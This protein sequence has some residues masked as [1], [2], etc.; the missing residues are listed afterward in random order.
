MKN[1]LVT[2]YEEIKPAP[3][4]ILIAPNYQFCNE[5]TLKICICNS[6]RIKN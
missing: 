1:S 5:L 2:I 6:S 4:R 3:P